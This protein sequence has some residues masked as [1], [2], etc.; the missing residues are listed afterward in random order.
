MAKSGEAERRRRVWDGRLR[1]V[2][3]TQIAF[4]DNLFVRVFTVAELEGQIARHIIDTG[5]DGTGR[6]D[7]VDIVEGNFGDDFLLQFVG[8]TMIFRILNLRDGQVRMGHSQRR[9]NLLADAAL[10]PEA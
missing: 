6:A 9:K 7:S 5:I 8:Q 10:P 3:F 2:H 4:G 1:S